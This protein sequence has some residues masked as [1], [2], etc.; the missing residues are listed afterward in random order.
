MTIIKVHI[1]PDFIGSTETGGIRRVSEGMLKYFPQFGVKHVSNVRDADIIIAHGAMQTKCGG[2]PII[3]VNHGLYWSRQQWGDGFFDVNG[4]LAD[5]MTAAVAHTAPSEWVS[6]A[7]RRGGLF[8]P[9]VIYHGVDM[10]DFTPGNNEGYV[11]WNKARADYVSD[12]EDMQMVAALLP[13]VQFRTTIGREAD[14]VRVIKPMPYDDMKKVVGNAG[15]YL[16]T[17]R[18]TFG[19][20][21]LE[22][23]AAGVP[24]AGWDWGGQSEIIIQGVTG[25]LAFP[26]DFEGLAEC[27]RLCLQHREILSKNCMADVKKR[28]GWEKRIEQYAKLVKK[29]YRDYYKLKRPRVSVIVT[30]YN[31]DKYLPDCLES[32]NRQTMGD[33]ECLVVDDAQLN[34]TKKI[35]A[36]FRKD[37]KRIR[38][39]PTL[40]NLGLPGAR[41]YG[42]YKSKG[43]FIRHLDADDF[44]ADNALELEAKALDE[45]QDVHIVYGHIETVNED[46]S[47]LLDKRGN[48]RRSGWP[49]ETFNW[50]EQMAH[51]NQLPSCVMMRREVLERSGGYRDRMKRNEDAEF[52]CRV[53]SLGFKAKKFTQAVTFFHRQRSDSKGA[54]EWAKEGREPDW[55]AWF[56]WR[57]GAD[58]FDE[59]RNVFR[60]NAGMHPN[61]ALVP[62]GAQ[63]K[64]TNTKFWYVHDYAYPVVSVIVTCGPKHERY[65]LDALDSVQAQSYPDWECIVV[66]DTGEV[67]GPDIMGAPY[68]KVV[69]MNGNEGVSAAR[70]KGFE[71]ARGRFVIWMDA[72]DYWLPWYLDRMV[73]YG[74]ENDGIIFSDMIQD[75]G[76]KLELYRYRE[77]DERRLSLDMRYAGSSVLVPRY[78][79]EKV[80]AL[81]GG[82]DCEIVGNEDWDYQIAVHS[83]GV[84]AYHIPEA[85]FVYRVYSSTKRKKDHARKEEIVEYLNNKWPRYLKEGIKMAC[86]CVK[87]TIVKRSPKSTLSSSSKLFDS[88]E[89]MI[90]ADEGQDDKIVSVEYFGPNEQNFSIRSKLDSQV[91]YKFGNNPHNK[92]KEVFL[93]D[94]LYLIGKIGRDNLQFYKI[95]TGVSAEDGEQDP[96]AALGG[97]VVGG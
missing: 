68:A 73:A 14:N 71:F 2:K 39:L 78:A 59:A 44:L 79:A 26:G 28:W 4:R 77:F 60:E 56:P 80:L 54:E 27:I 87:K 55:T 74:E 35:V 18:E 34:S 38:Y 33:Y 40:N 72:D 88:P 51:M 31:L 12:P 47:R 32:V 57:M 94:A 83:T 86:G 89:E 9:E 19:I 11:L 64:P 10:E 69:N 75:T 7:M 66:N 48:P 3:N 6:K 70:N 37:N 52:W 25:Y 41:N 90:V 15:V 1:S 42:F 81:Q 61:P 20:G 43:R 24:V 30:A 58:G 97:R 63:G 82:W 23:M 50:F 36:G 62:F 49:T 16:C 29:V 53:T 95:V 84:C 85:L 67:W 45:D 65:L 21:T 76:D 92:I 8:Y 46:G 93:K 96:Q 13:S 22:A 91:R 17:A 5:A